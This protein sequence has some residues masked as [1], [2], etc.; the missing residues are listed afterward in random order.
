MHNPE[1]YIRHYG[2]AEHYHFYYI[3]D[4]LG[5]I[6]ETYVH[7]EADYKECVERTQYYP[8]GLPWVERLTDSFTANPWKYNGK[9]FVEM[10]GLDEFDSK[11]RWY[12]PAICRTTT[13][14]PYAVL[15]IYYCLNYYQYD[16]DGFK[17]TH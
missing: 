1:G 17:I 7:P 11:A 2:P 9:E 16:Q 5:N 3:K 6:R 8:S 14:D 10:H 15:Q 13:M 4:L 12:Y